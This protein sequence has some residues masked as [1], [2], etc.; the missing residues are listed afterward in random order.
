MQALKKCGYEKTDVYELLK[1][2]MVG[3]PAQVFTRYHEKNITQIRFH[4]YGEKD[5]LIKVV[6]GGDPNGLYFHCSGNVMPCGK[7]TLA[8]SR[9]PYDQKQ[10]A[11]FSKNVLKEKFL[12]LR[13]LTL[14]YRTSFM[15]RL[16]RCRR[17]FLFKRFLI[18][19]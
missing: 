7:E 6:I 16:V 4:V 1:I 2:G 3:V 8:V 17:C 15:T 11:K 19:P 14:K 10:I 9:K 12:G 13:R 18:V 5:K